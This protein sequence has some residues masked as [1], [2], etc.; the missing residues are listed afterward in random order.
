MSAQPIGLNISICFVYTLVYQRNENLSEI[1]MQETSV[2]VVQP[3]E[4]D[5]SSGQKENK[6]IAT[7]N[8]ILL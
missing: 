5:F 8:W 7:A 1:C 6:T 4:M 2:G 3:D